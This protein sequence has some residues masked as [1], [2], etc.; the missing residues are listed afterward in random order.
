MLSS[1]QI[2]GTEPSN[3][4]VAQLCK[5]KDFI[6]LRVAPD[7]ETMTIVRPYNSSHHRRKI[8]NEGYYA[9]SHLWRNAKDFPSWQVGTFITENGDPVDDIPMRPEKR[10]TLL[11]LLK[12]H[13]GSYWWIDVLCARTDTPLVIMGD[14]YKHCKL[15][16]AMLDCEPEFVRRIWENKNP[17]KHLGRVHS[18]LGEGFFKKFGILPSSS[19]PLMA[20]LIKVALKRYPW[21]LD[22]LCSIFACNWFDR[23]WT[24]QEIA[25]PKTTML[26]ERCGNSGIKY[27]LSFDKDIMTII[28]PFSLRKED[29]IPGL[30][31]DDTAL[32]IDTLSRKVQSILLLKSLLNATKPFPMFN[33]PSDPLS[34]ASI[35]YVKLQA[36]AECN[37]TCTNT[38]DYVYGV[39]GLIGVHVPRYDQPKEVWMAF[40]S[41][42]DK[43]FKQYAMN[44]KTGVQ[45]MTVSKHA[46]DF[47]LALAKDLSDV[48]RGLVHTHRDVILFATSNM[49]QE[50]MQNVRESK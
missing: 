11:A 24:L 12:D 26:S 31:D 23:V 3:E 19:V 50:W 1:Q 48:Y 43:H 25:L 44:P 13:P 16:Y 36:L 2:L 21:M 18:S 8:M 29:F 40:L 15:C 49:T 45:L 5:N 17:M 27:Q 28:S 20:P 33:S 30:V 47:D 46:T 42:L 39:L 41:A 14:I 38:V 10:H 6:L 7:K 9:L 22:A 4:G 32:A 34:H 37:R 35:M